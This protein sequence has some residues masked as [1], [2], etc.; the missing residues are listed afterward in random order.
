MFQVPPDMYHS[1]PLLPTL[2]T[3]LSLSVSKHCKE[4]HSPFG[5]HPFSVSLMHWKE[6]GWANL[7]K[8]KSLEPGS[9]SWERSRAHL[10]VKLALVC[11][12]SVKLQGWLQAWEALQKST[13]NNR[14]VCCTSWSCM[15]VFPSVWWL[16]G[17]LEKKKRKKN[18]VR[19]TP[20][21]LIFWCIKHKPSPWF[22]F[23]SIEIALIH[24]GWKFACCFHF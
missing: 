14:T 5:T 16:N 9:Q 6:L 24:L 21:C 11:V 4:N 22:N 3:P 1:F 18:K 17:K 20:K 23:G 8:K 19:L 2:R 10:L 7:E 15:D 12:G 13:K